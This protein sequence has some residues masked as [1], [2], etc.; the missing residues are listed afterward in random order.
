MEDCIDQKASID[1]IIF[2]SVFKFKKQLP[3]STQTRSTGIGLHISTMA[4][5][6]RISMGRMLFIE[7]FLTDLNLYGGEYEKIERYAGNR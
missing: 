3:V 5:K 4:I 6:I 2:I 7:E 1:L